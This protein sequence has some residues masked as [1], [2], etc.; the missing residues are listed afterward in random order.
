MA[1]SVAYGSS[2]ARDLIWAAAATYATTTATPDTFKPLVWAGIRT[3]TSAVTWASVV[4]LL[5][6]GATAGTPKLS[7]LQFKFYFL[8]FHPLWR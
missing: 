1:T 2:W 7:L 5:T 3:Y 8:S 6:H 4:G